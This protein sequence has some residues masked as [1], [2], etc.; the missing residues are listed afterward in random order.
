MQDWFEELERQFLFDP[1]GVAEQIV[2]LFFLMPIIRAECASFVDTWNTHTIR[3]QR[4]KPHIIPGVP[5]DLYFT[6]DDDVLN[7][8]ETPDPEIL[9]RYEQLVA[10]VGKVF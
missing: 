6:P 9:A 4:S 1:K 5:D 8:G 7:Y 3:N 10:D 2:V